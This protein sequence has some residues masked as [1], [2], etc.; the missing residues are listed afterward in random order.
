MTRRLS[1]SESEALALAR[2]RKLEDEEDRAAVLRVRKTK[3]SIPWE[4]IKRDLGLTPAR[5]G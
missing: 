3:G 4:V 1:T 2:V 5:P